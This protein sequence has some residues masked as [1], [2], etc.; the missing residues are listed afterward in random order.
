M[1]LIQN[2]LEKAARKGAA[3]SVAGLMA[4]VGMGFLTAAFW[5]VLSQ[6]RTDLFATTVIG[7]IYFGAGAVIAALAMRKP[8]APPK[9]HLSPLQLMIVSFLDGFEQ[10]QRTKK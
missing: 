5:M 7:L 1:L 9:P 8:P 10:A 2:K 6:W 4:L 3:F